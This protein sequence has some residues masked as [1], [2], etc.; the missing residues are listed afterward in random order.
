MDRCIRADYLA[1]LHRGR[2][3]QGRGERVGPA[4]EAHNPLE[5]H[6]SALMSG[7]TRV[8]D[9]YSFF[10][11]PDPELDVGCQ[12]GSGSKSEYG[13]RALMTKNLKKITAENFFKI[14]FDQKLQFTYP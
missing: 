11:D 8:V 9:P 7:E 3:A 1:H 12:Y 13:S 10:T 2:L 4:G 6:Q 5:R 14:F